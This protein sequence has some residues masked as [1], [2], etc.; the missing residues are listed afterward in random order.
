MLKAIVSN[1]VSAVEGCVVATLA[2]E[3]KVLIP[4][5]RPPAYAAWAHWPVSREFPPL[6]TAAGRD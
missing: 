2:R 4:T 6:L 1:R 3:T 5:M